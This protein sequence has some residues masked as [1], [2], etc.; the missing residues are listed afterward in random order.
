MAVVSVF[1]TVQVL[2]EIREHEFRQGIRLKC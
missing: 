1:M 2:F